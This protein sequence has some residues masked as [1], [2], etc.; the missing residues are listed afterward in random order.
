MKQFIGSA[1]VISTVA[2]S[3]AACN[4]GSGGG[5]AGIGG[6]GF[7]SSGSVSGFGSVY[8]NGVKF[9]TDNAVFDIEG[10]Q[11]VQ[12]DLSIGMRVKVYGSINNDGVSGVASRVEFDDQLEGPISSAISEG[13]DLENKTFTVL[14]VT[15]NVNALETVFVGAGF[16]YATISAGDNVQ[17]SG[18]YDEAGVLHVT[19]AVKKDDFVANNTNVEVKGTISD[20]DANGF[21]LSAGTSMLEVIINS[22]EVSALDGE[23]DDGMFVEV[24][25]TIDAADSLSILASSIEQETNLP[26]EGIEV[27]VEGVVSRFVSDADFDVDGI[28]VDASSAVKVPSSVQIREGLRLEVEGVVSEGVLVAEELIL[29]DGSVEIKAYVSSVNT[30][31]GL[32][33]VEIAGQAI[34]VSVDESTRFENE[35]TGD[36]LSLSNLSSLD[37]QFVEISGVEG[38]NNT[39]IATRVEVD[40]ADD[41]ELEGVL[42]SQVIGTSVRV[43][44][45]DIP[46]NASTEYSNENNMD[47][48]SGVAGQTA[49]SALVVPG[50][51]V[52][53]VEDKEPLDGV[54]DEVE[55]Q[56]P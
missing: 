24:E 27:E 5:I 29:K 11:G 31:A 43:L 19:A 52:I 23:L 21:T 7:T 54:A 47:I 39:V 12:D 4:G 35:E 3:L 14:G 42:Q 53:E 22:A 13:L 1:L 20:L 30:S 46:V 8:V 34:S 16:S 33:D 37:G 18:F 55:I 50:E 15:V 10:I 26:A 9:E 56:Q 45:I 49:F 6:S 25:G 41:V 38:E 32:F 36:P 44:G 28:P 40:E 2:A 17:F 48:G 51:T